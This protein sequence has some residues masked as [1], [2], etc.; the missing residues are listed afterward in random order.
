[1]RGALIFFPALFWAASLAAV[2]AGVLSR[3]ARPGP[4]WLALIGALAV[5]VAEWLALFGPW[6]PPWGG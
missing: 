2:G 5:V 3:G 1:M 4:G 6:T